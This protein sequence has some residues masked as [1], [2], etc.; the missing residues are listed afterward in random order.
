MKHA[1][2]GGAPSVVEGMGQR[3]RATAK[4]R[5]EGTVRLANALVMM[6]ILV[7]LA[8]GGGGSGPVQ[9]STELEQVATLAPA[10]QERFRTLTRE[11][12]CLV[13]QNQSIADSHAEL[14]QDL[15]RE[16]LERIAAGQSDAEILDF[17]VTRY[18]DFVLYKP[19]LNQNTLLLWAGPGALVLLGALVF[20]RVV[21]TRAA[22]PMAPAVDAAP[23]N[24]QDGQDT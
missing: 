18:G 24:V 6:L 15:R 20:F 19:P 17:L 10:E 14:A 2:F 12:R 1:F 4:G 13:C 23:E 5:R 22:M 7:C 21:R 9:A 8:A 3:V 11:I 16:V